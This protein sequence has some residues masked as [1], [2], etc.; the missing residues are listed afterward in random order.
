MKMGNTIGTCGV[1][2]NQ[3]EMISIWMFQE[4]LHEHHDFAVDIVG[5]KSSQVVGVVKNMPANAGD[6]RPALN[7]WFWR[8][9]VAGNG[10][11]LLVPGE[12]HV[13]RSLGGYSPIWSQRVGYVWKD[14]ANT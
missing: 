2:N 3:I 5:Y 7:P 11:G 1:S 12:S 8:S 6:K 13:Q 14:L 9:P 10:N 4:M